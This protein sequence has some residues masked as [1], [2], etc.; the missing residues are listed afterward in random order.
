MTIRP[1]PA[2]AA[3]FA[4]LLLPALLAPPAAAA[5]LEAKLYVVTDWT[6]GNFGIPDWCSGTN[7]EDWAEM[8][9]GWYYAVDDFGAVSLDG[10]WHNGLLNRGL[11]CDPDTGLPGCTD[12]DRIDEADVAM[13]GFHGGDSNGHWRGSMAYSGGAAGGDCGIDVPESGSGEMYV[14]DADLEFLHLSSCHSMDDDNLFNVWRMFEDPVDSP[15]SKRRL[16]LATGFHGIMWISS[17][18]DDD[19]E[20][21]AWAAHVGISEAWLDNLWDYDVGDGDWEQCPVAYAIGSGES[22]C[23]SRL[24]NESYFNVIGPDPAISYHCAAGFSGCHPKN[25]DPFNIP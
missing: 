14:G 4:A 18:R 5:S 8:L 25:D 17:G 11:F 6:L 21:F 7:V 13:I 23:L 22:D 20:S 3:L 10:R 15:K 19:Y 1:E 12:Y 16:H 24:S 9:D 2:R